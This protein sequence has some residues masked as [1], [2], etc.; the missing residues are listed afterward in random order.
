MGGSNGLKLN[1][2]STK[3]Q[4]GTIAIVKVRPPHDFSAFQDLSHLLSI[5][6]LKELQ[7]RWADP[8]E[9]IILLSVQN[10]R[11]LSR[12]LNQTCQI[13]S[14]LLKHFRHRARE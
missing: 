4:G 13:E 14:L 10:S 9:I 12:L 7:N 1:S 6:F 8:Y 2:S 3:I 5:A 11:N